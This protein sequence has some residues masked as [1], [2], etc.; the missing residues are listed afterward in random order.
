[1]EMSSGKAD[2]MKLFTTGKLKIS[3]NVMASQ[4][5]E[6]LQKIDKEQAM[7]AAKDARASGESAQ[8]N[9]ASEATDT[10]QKQAPAIFAAL[11]KALKRGAY[12]HET[13]T[14]LAFRLQDQDATWWVT[15][16][17]EG[18][19]VQQD[20]NTESTDTTLTLDDATLVALVQGEFTAQQ[21]YTRGQMR[22]DGHVQH[23]HQL[24]FLLGLLQ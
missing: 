24:P 12:K 13:T 7:A 18:G 22:V 4:K 23:A 19:S 2:P 16:T 5:L 14:T 15:L 11:Q 20:T 8:T 17:P 1:M 10:Q 21:A 9:T 3:G 6:F